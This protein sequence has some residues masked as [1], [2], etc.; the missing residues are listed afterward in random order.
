MLLR[1]QLTFDQAG[2]V[3]ES[4]EDATTGKKTLY[5]QGICIQGGVRNLNERNYPVDEITKAV[6][7]INQ[8]LQKGESVLGECDH[9]QE[10]TIN[11]D[12]VSHMIEKMWMKDNCGMGK[13]KIVPTPHGQIIRTLIE[14]GVKLG[15]SSRGSG[16]V[17][18]RGNVSD[19]EI[20]TVDIVARPSAPNA[21]PSPVYEAFNGRRGAVLE[22]LARAV[23]HDPKAQRY[24]VT[25]A[26]NWIDNLK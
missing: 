4:A 13:L 26:M 5:M 3:V 8:V 9:P 15:V 25:E 22:D 7:N 6:G 17:D 18:H 10:L 20:V 19:F 1:E 23:Y 11:L 24:L 21:Y 14:S 12:R 2:L 16:N